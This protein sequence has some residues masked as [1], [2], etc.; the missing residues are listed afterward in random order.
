MQDTLFNNYPN[1]SVRPASV[2]D[3]EFDHS[4]GS[5]DGRWGKVT[6]V[7]LGRPPRVRLTRPMFTSRLSRNRGGH[8]VLFSRHLHRHFPF[9]RDSYWCGL[10][11]AR[12]P[13]LEINAFSFRTQIIP[14]WPAQRL[15]IATRRPLVI[16]R[17]CR[18]PTRPSQNRYSTSSS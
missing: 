15:T 5:S 1:L 6:G 16:P 17:P 3:L 11:P 12:S 9:G 4:Q 8:Q 10:M 2:F 14:S 13:R 7:K 18:L